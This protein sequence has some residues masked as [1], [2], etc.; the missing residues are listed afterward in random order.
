MN[1]TKI[2]TLALAVMMSAPVLRAG[3]E[4]VPGVERRWALGFHT[5]LEQPGGGRPIEVDLQGDWVST[6]SAVRPGEY[7]AE[8]QLA[9]AKVSGAAPG[10]TPPNAGEQL[11]RRL[12]R[13]FWVTYREDGALLAVHFFKDVDPGERNLLQ[14]IATETELVETGDDRAG[15]TV[16]ERDGAGEYMAIYSRQGPGVIVKRKLKYAQTDGATGAPV[17]GVHVDIE[18]SEARFSVDGNGSILSFD[19]SNR[20]RIGVAVQGAGQLTATTETHLA[21][22]RA[23]SAPERIGSLARALPDV[24]TAAVVTHASGP[25]ELRKRFDQRLLEG[26]TTESLLQAAMAKSDDKMLPARLA[27]LFRQRSEAAASALALLGAS[28][29]QKLI[30]GALGSAGSPAAVDALAAIARDCTL[31]PELRSDALV[32]FMFIEHPS[33]EAMRA[34]LALLD[35]T[36]TRIASLARLTSGAVSRMGRI[37]HPADADA[38]DATLI[39][40][41]RKAQT[42]SELTGLLTAMGNSASA[43]VLPTIK[44]GLRDSRAA[45]RAAAAR[46]LRLEPGSDIDALLAKTMVADPDSDVRY[47]AIYAC[48][49]RR[50][51][52]VQI[53]EATVH[54]AKEDTSESVRS[55]AVSLLRNN[56]K[57]VSGIAETLEWVAEH[58]SKPGM[59][60]LASEAVAS[61]R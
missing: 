22:F 61:I 17:G 14:M 5:R 21:N 35:D 23:S 39:A 19:G 6:I 12:E 44:D 36:D 38:I 15:W 34:P 47:A 60:K 24:E 11:A 46:A 31:S 1:T 2:A 40:R 41:F 3:A 9:N 32:A 45:V 42:A 25:V 7:D 37:A 58:D 54:S 28:G 27:A 10:N 26:H 8:F 30:T 16:L 18:K 52:G 20:V 51:I 13:R 55:A 56:P 57:A 50:P 29:T 4:A 59:R 48:T 53:G 43:S 49:F 33:P